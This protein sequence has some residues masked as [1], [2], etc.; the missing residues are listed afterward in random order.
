VRG[1]GTIDDKEIAVVEGIAAW[2]DIN[3]ESIFD[4]RPWN[5][6]GEGPAADAANPIR[7]QGFNEGRV[8]FT[9]K[10]IRFN[11]N[12]KI[13]YVT[14]MGTPT[15]SITIRNLGTSVSSA[16]ISKIEMLGSKEKI[17]WTQ[18][19][20]LLK[21]EKPTVIPNPIAV[22]FKVYQK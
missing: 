15:E 11:Q 2:M 3:K 10:D 1:D 8:K 20:D 18:Q 6:F 7:A 13:L 9:A 22:V 21:I 5:V 14:V 12:G 19:A 16:N 4:T 17:K